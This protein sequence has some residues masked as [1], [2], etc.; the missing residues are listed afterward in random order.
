MGIAVVTGSASGIGAALAERL[1]PTHRVIGIDLAG[2][3][4]EVDLGTSDGRRSAIDEVHRLSE[5]ALDVVVAAAGIGPTGRRPSQLVAVN[6]F[7]TVEILMGLR[8]LLSQGIDPT[9]LAVCSNTISCHRNPVPEHLVQL[10]LDGDEVKAKRAADEELNSDVSY[11]VSKIAQMRWMRAQAISADW[12]GAGI[13]LNGLAPGNTDTA[14]F[15]ERFTDGEFA[16]N[17]TAVMA[18]VPAGRTLTADEVAGVAH[19]LVGPDGAP[20]VGSVVFCDGGYDALLN[21]TSPSPLV[22]AP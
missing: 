5:G 4:I 18:A 12:I 11:P 1:R 3:D 14:M 20:F 13:R 10:C 7:G 22:G 2:A 16:S 15:A 9:A 19:F 21:P 6:Y 17:A 8:P